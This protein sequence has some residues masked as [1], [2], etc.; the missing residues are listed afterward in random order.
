MF[1]LSGR[2]LAW[3]AA[4]LSI[5]NLLQDANLVSL[6]A[7]VATWAEAYRRL[8]NAIF[9]FLFSWIPFSWFHIGEWE[10]HGLVVAFT[11][12]VTTMRAQ[13][14][15]W[16]LGEDALPTAF[17]FLALVV[18]AGVWPDEWLEGVAM[19][20]APFAFLAIVYTRAGLMR[21]RAFATQLSSIAATVLLIVVVNRMFLA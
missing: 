20:V 15:G 11:L 6:Y 19:V 13:H 9:Q 8:I 2:I 10:Q 4:A 21:P 1:G 3:I 17:I 7:S 18:Q 5:L 14:G 16:R 12:A